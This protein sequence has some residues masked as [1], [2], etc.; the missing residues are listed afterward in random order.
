MAST[1]INRLA[2]YK[3]KI[4]NKNHNSNALKHG[5]RFKQ[6]Q[7]VREKFSQKYALVIKAVYNF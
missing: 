6:V 7:S 2:S 3:L 5:H 1:E 4:L